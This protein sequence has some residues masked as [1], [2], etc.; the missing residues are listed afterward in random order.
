[1]GE[2]DQV[3]SSFTDNVSLSLQIIWM[4][5]RHNKGIT[6]TCICYFYYQ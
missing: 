6:K 2:H 4:V 5:L 1:M 3:K